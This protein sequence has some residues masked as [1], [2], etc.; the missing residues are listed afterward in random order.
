MDYTV[1]ENSSRKN[2][3]VQLRVLTK[4]VLCENILSMIEEA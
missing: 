1:V 2:Q 3:S 4:A